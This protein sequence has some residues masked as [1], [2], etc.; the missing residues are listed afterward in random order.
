ML[1]HDIGQR[2]IISQHFTIADGRDVLNAVSWGQMLDFIASS[3][4][5]DIACMVVSS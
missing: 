5:D 4:H 1:M 2:P 3:P